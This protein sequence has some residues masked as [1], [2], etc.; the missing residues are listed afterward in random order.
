M[1]SINDRTK[2]HYWLL[3]AIFGEPLDE[4]FSLSDSESENLIDEFNAVFG[5]LS[6]KEVQIIT[7]RFGLESGFPMTIDEMASIL[8]D[9]VDEVQSMEISIIQKLRH[10]ARSQILRPFLGD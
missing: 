3:H 7:L 4:N 10:P 8:G 9:S 5:T 1:T 2:A 6:N